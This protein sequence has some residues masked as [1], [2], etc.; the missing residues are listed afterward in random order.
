MDSLRKDGQTLTAGKKSIVSSSG[1]PWLTWVEEINFGKIAA[2]RCSSSYTLVKSS[3]VAF[4]H[5]QWPTDH[6]R[7]QWS[8][9]CRMAI[10]VD[11]FEFLSFLINAAQQSFAVCWRCSASTLSFH[12]NWT[13]LLDIRKERRLELDEIW[14]LDRRIYFLFWLRYG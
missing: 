14:S 13:Q 4:R 3:V 12:S 10:F 8:A 11:V 5:F 2:K 1:R 9:R 6:W 7:I